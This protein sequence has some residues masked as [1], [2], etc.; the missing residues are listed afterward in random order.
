MSALLSESDLN[1]FIVLPFVRQTYPGELKCSTRTRI[2]GEHGTRSTEKV[3]L[4]Y[5]T[6]SCVLVV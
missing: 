4:R 3:S 6:A 2:R 5:Q 1:D